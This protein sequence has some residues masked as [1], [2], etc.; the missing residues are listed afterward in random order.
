M[1]ADAQE[2]R[3][4]GET[5]PAKRIA[6]LAEPVIEA[7]GYRLVRVRI[8]GPGGGTLQVMAERPDGTM[9]LED[10]EL[11]SR[12]LGPLLDVEDPM[13]GPYQLEI[14]SPGIDRPLVRPSDFIRWSG[15]EAKIEMTEAI[16]GR[17]RFRGTLEGFDQGEILI[18]IDG[19]GS[20][21]EPDI[22]RLP[23]GQVAEAKLVMTDALLEDVRRT[24]LRAN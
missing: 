24:P 11:I 13:P 8:T 12:T 10:C 6:D 7:L 19:G 3:I 4:G 14:S 1:G 15:H 23:F 16:G 9:S 20:G 21:S 18:A 2:P 17:R 5:G 22:V